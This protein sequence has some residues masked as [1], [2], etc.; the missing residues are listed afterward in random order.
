M[1][2]P[3]VLIT[4]AS[5][6]IGAAIARTFAREVRGVR[7]ALV[8]R[9]ARNLA[10]VARAC[11]RAAMGARLKD[12]SLTVD[13]DA[14]IFAFSGAKDGTIIT[15]RGTRLRIAEIQRDGTKA[16]RLICGPAGVSVR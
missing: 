5:Q 8:A 16:V 12:V 7:L 6:G 3:V 13:V 11:D 15:V 4:G 9:N 1:S 2:N 14:G 10:T